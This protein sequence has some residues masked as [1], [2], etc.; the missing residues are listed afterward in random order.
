MNPERTSSGKPNILQFVM[1]GLPTIVVIAIMGGGWLLIHHVTSSGRTT[2]HNP[3]PQAEVTQADTLV[4]PDGKIKAGNFRSAPAESQPL[5]HMH[6]V[7]G[8]L[9]YDETKHIDV[10]APMDGI[11]SELLVTPGDIVSVGQRIAVLRS[12]E[13][14][15]ARA[16]F[17]KRRQE[18]EIVQK[19]LERE[20]VLADNFKAL[21]EM[22]DA[23][24]P[25]SAI[26]AAFQ[27]RP[28][29]TYRQDILSAYSNMQMADQHIAKLR[30]LVESGAV[31]GRTLRERTN[32]RQLAETAFRTACD[33]AKFFVEQAQ[34]KAVAEA[35]EAERQ[36][37][38]A[39]Q[40]VE[41]LLGYK[42]DRANTKLADDNALSQ[43]EVRAPFGGTVESRGYAKNERVMRGDSLIVLANTDSLTVEAS[44]REGDWSAVALKPGTPIHVAVPALDGRS[45]EA[46]VRYFG[47]EVQADTNSVPLVASIQ[48]DEGLLRPGMFVRVTLPV[49]EMREVLAVKS[50][51]IIQ[52]ENQQFVFVD[53]QG[54]TFKRVDVNTGQ[55]SEDW[56]EV[57]NG[58][59]P[60]QLVVTNGAFL[61]KSEL[62]LQG[63]GE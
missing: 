30:P 31:P 16:A 57:T 4:L 53:L 13:I 18:R 29:G 24:E 42:E 2:E 22:L 52:H 26:E 34:L 21:V 50:E 5:Q 8:R 45:F 43:L 12:P 1:Q 6:T 25:T 41:T 44:I 15:Q 55:A 32:E 20:T 56:I 48:N 51:S 63:E 11:L 35:A 7:P 3:E 36:V 28:L 46:D 37:N 40:A 23:S 33:Q 49:G 19:I 61:L 54:G 47:R 17:I 14:G 10:K 62:L 39:W 38:L 59:R 60:G 58:L 9:R 27:D